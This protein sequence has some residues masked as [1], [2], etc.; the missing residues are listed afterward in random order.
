MLDALELARRVREAMDAHK[1]KVTSVALADACKVTPQAV[2]G[3]RKTGRLHK[4]HLATIAKLTDRPLSW[5]LSAATEMREP[6]GKY[7]IE[8]AE[9]ISRLRHA[10]PDWRRYVLSLAMIDKGKQQLMLDTMREAV[11]DHIVEKALG[12]APHVAK[13]KALKQHD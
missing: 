2:N 9:A 11:P 1:P 3:W 12:D 8:E 13:R 6:D 7:V 5:F 4:K 10:L